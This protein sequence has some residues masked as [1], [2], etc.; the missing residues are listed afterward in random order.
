M[1]Q[2]EFLSAVRARL[3]RLPASDVERFLDYCREMI[4]DRMEDGLSEAEAIAAMG[5]P[6]YV[7]SQFLMDAGSVKPAAN[8][9]PRQGLKTW[10]IVLIV[11]GSPVWAP[12]L[13]ALAAAAVSVIVGL[14]SALFGLHCAAGGIIIGGFGTIIGG[15]V[16]I[17]MPDLLFA[18]AA[19]LL[20]IGIGLLMSL[21]LGWLDG[22]L[23][24]LIKWIWQALSSRLHR[25][26]ISQ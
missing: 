24:R 3:A 23:I 17:A 15:A 7:A 12:V 16:K 4:D 25:K 10:Q 9:A 11:L 5:S 21:G 13:L 18:L 14:I 19:G 1:N 8:K 6:E 26:E 22:Q 20:L 2:H